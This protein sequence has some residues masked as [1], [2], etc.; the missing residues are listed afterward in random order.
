[1]FNLLLL[2][3][4]SNG[5]HSELTGDVSGAVHGSVGYVGAGFRLSIHRQWLG[6]F[7]YNFLCCSLCWIPLHFS[8]VPCM[9]R[10]HHKLPV[11]AGDVCHLPTGNHGCGGF[12]C[13]VSIFE[14]E[15]LISKPY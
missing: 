6:K 4:Q 3:H 9:L 5:V 13:C 7:L 15:S 2:L 11:L 12:S 14:S 10:C 8:W 1:M